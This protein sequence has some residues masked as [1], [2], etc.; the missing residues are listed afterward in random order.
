MQARNKNEMQ[1]GM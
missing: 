1:W